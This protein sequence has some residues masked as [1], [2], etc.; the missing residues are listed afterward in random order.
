[1]EGSGVLFL[2]ELAFA[3]RYS[4]E[5]F[6]P[7]SRE[8]RRGTFMPESAAGM[9]SVFGRCS[10]QLADLRMMVVH[11]VR[12]EGEAFAILVAG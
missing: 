4:L 2:G 10:L 12:R 7:L 6:V 9:P 11:S 1:M 8:P 5:P 3:G